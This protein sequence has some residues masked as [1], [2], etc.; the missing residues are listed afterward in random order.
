[1][2]SEALTVGWKEGVEKFANEKDKKKGNKNSRNLQEA[3]EEAQYW[4]EHGKPKPGS[5]LD[6]DEGSGESGSGSDSADEPPPQKK[7]G[8]PKK[9]SK[10]DKKDQ[11]NS[12]S[13]ESDDETGSHTKVCNAMICPNHKNRK[14]Q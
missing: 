9:S 8:R 2:V 13:K 7:R 14:R 5:K 1:M 11:D 3:I 4:L 10:D 6:E 12:K